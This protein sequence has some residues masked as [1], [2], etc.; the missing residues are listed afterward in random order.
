MV[1]RLARMKVETKQRWKE[2]AVL[3]DRLEA[4]LDK[5]KI[6]QMFQVYLTMYHIVQ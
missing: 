4:A 3:R 6:Q 1:R 2:N 5:V